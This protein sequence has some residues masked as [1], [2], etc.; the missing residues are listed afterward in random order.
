MPSIVC[1]SFHLIYASRRRSVGETT[2]TK[3]YYRLGGRLDSAA[4]P[5]QWPRAH[6]AQV[7]GRLQ[8]VARH[9]ETLKNE[10]AHKLA[11]FHRML[12]SPSSAACYDAPSRLCL[13]RKVHRCA[14]RTRRRT[15]SLLPK[16]VSTSVDESKRGLL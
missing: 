11:S 9:T 5:A 2:L 16:E 12:A 13:D 7:R 6:S 8:D 4:S 15:P 3:R 10:M 14:N 1:P